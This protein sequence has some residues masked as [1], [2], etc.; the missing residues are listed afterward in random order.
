MRYE[1]YLECSKQAS[2]LDLEHAFCQKQQALAVL[3][4]LLFFIIDYKGKEFYKNNI[5]AYLNSMTSHPQ[6]GAELQP[7]QRLY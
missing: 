7:R 3:N 1:R 6:S 4:T 5:H 2:I